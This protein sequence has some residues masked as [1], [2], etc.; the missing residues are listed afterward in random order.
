M[1]KVGKK[2][3]L[4]QV[5]ACGQPRRSF[6]SGILGVAGGEEAGSRSPSSPC[7]AFYSLYLK[8]HQR[9]GCGTGNF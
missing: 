3:L 5:C 7:P 1:D 8:T 9:G 4:G 2:L 6:S